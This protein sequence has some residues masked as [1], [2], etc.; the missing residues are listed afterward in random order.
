M[1]IQPDDLPKIPESLRVRFADTVYSIYLSTGKLT[2][3]LCKEEGHLAR[4]SK[5]NTVQDT[6][7]HSGGTN[8]GMNVLQI[9]NREK[10]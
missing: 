8:N 3:L 6:S 4:Y 9:G 1:Y 7:E 2:C 10:C 5:E